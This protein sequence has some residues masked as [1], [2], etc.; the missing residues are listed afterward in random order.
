MLLE[1]L[2]E[3]VN[4]NANVEIYNAANQ[5]LLSCYDGKDSIDERYN[6]YEVTDVFG[7][8]KANTICIEIDYEEDD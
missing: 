5:D 8:D 7:T 4:E 1:E 6:D 3:L 2:L